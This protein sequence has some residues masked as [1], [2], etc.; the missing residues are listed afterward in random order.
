MNY[1]NYDPTKDKDAV[2]RIWREIGWLED[3]KKKN[4]AMD[5]FVEAG[6]A[7]VAD[8]RG[9]A[10]CLV[11]TMPGVI[12]HLQD[13]LALCAVTSVTTSRIARKQGFASR[14]TARAIANDAAEGACVAGLGIFDQGFYNQLGFGNGSYVHWASF[15]PAQ[16]LIR[17]G[18]R[19]PHRLTKDDWNV[20]HGARLA[21]PRRHGGCNL[22]SPEATR[23]EM[24]WSDNGFG[25][26]YYD[27]PNGELTHHFWA[28]SKDEHG[29][30]NIWWMSYETPAQFMELMALLKSFGDQI[31][32]I[33]M[34]EPPGIQM[35]DLLKQPFRHRS[36]SRGGKFEHK[37]RASAYWQLRICDVE[38]CLS[39]THL[40]GESTRFNLKLHDP[41]ERYL[42]VGAPWRG[43]SGDYIVTLGPD[44][45]AECGI[46][47]SLPTLTASVGAFTRLWMGI[48]SASGLAVTDNLSG[49]QDLLETLDWVLRLP[50]PNLNWDF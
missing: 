12:R 41:I 28:T 47:A 5:R 49:P 8:V 33:N 11:L 34:D 31:H 2:H 18:F 25:L 6:Q 40:R 27:G 38:G 15:D 7:L 43:V 42:D 19:S 13:D 35:Q 37:M 30:L 9:E 39:K 22:S 20:V 44:S 1:R 26:G 48:G 23:A 29:P 17:R 45:S 3:D 10:E 16:L 50:T 14:L 24:D 21:R 4:E 36:V 46:E 32:L